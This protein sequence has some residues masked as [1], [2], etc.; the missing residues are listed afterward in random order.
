MSCAH[1]YVLRLCQAT[2]LPSL[3]VLTAHDW[4]AGNILVALMHVYGVSHMAMSFI[5]RP[6]IATQD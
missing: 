6:G 4:G 2:Y 3:P 1:G 5:F